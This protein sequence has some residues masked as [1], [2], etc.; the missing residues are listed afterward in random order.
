MEKKLSNQIM[1]LCGQNN[2]V[3]FDVNVGKVPTVFGTYFDS[4]LP[5]GFPDLL[6]LHTDGRV[7]FIEVKVKPNKPSQDQIDFIKF[8]RSRNFF[9]D[10]VFSIDDMKKLIMTDFTEFL[11]YL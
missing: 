3:S 6:L 1:L 2:I 8:L 7:I 11:Y 4:G 9:A 5:N 10:V